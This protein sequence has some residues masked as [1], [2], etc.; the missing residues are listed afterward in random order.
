MATGRT[1]RLAAGMG[2]PAGDEVSVEGGDG[3]VGAFAKPENRSG[4]GCDGGVVGGEHGDVTLEV[5]GE[6][7][8]GGCRSAGGYGSGL[9]AARGAARGGGPALG[10]AIEGVGAGVLPRESA[11]GTAATARAARGAGGGA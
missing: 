7:E 11:R 5:G 3:V 10:G 4:E 8:G 9:G 1:K 6:A 2:E